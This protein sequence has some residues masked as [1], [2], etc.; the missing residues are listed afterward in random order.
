VFF[1]L[2]FLLE[3]ASVLVFVNKLSLCLIRIRT[4]VLVLLRS[5]GCP[6]VGRQFVWCGILWSS[7]RDVYEYSCGAKRDNEA[8]N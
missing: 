7:S 8:F 3:I 4:F 1:L 2:P 6:Y 5:Y